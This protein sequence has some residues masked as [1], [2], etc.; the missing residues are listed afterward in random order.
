[1]KINDKYKGNRVVVVCQHTQ[2]FYFGLSF[3]RQGY[4]HFENGND[5]A[6]YDAKNHTTFYNV[7]GK[8]RNVIKKGVRNLNNGKKID[9]ENLLE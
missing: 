8:A 3:S 7:S 9:L 1:M 4:E 2:G 6:T 5:L